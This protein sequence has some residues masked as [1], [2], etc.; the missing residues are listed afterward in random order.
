MKTTYLL[1]VSVS[2][3]G[4]FFISFLGDIII[5]WLLK[6]QWWQ[7]AMV[8][9]VVS[10]LT[11]HLVKSKSKT[12]IIITRS[13]F[14]SIYSCCIK[15]E[16]K[17]FVQF[18]SNEPLLH[19]IKEERCS[20]FGFGESKTGIITRF[21]LFLFF[22]LCSCLSWRSLLLLRVNTDG[23]LVDFLYF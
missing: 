14:Q 8:V 22:G 21:V 16:A 6:Q 5:M 15:K 20:F 23:L 19:I 18:R 4:N 11:Y 9:V 1:C 7:N 17:Y 3:S 10:G 12:A 13:Q 2:L